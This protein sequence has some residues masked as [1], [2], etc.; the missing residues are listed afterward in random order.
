MTKK[1]ALIKGDGCGP[2]LVN[3]ML[4]VFAAVQSEVQFIPCDAG[5]EWWQIHGGQSFIPPETWA[6]IKISDACFKGPTTTLPDPNT[7]RSVAVSLRQ[8]LKLYANIRPIKTFPR[9]VGP[10]GEVD[11]V[12]VREATEGL[13]SGLEHRISQDVAITIRKITRQASERVAKK[14]FE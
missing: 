1:V 8:S 11:F 9:T 12:C 6:I 3:S 13:Y 5:L 4:N 2:E 14:A 10:L 7:P